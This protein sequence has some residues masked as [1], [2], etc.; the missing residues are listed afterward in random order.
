MRTNSF[1]GLCDACS[2]HVAAGSGSLT[3]KPGR[4]RTWC[5]A[6]SPRPPARGAHDGWHRLPLASLDFETTGV[7]PHADR[8]VSYALLDEP[9][10]EITGLIDPGVP[11][12]TAASDVHG[13][14]ETMVAGAPGPAEAL[15]VVIDWVQAL[16]ERRVGLVVFNA[17]Y[18][19]TMLRAEAQRHGLA[20]PDWERLLV[21]DPYVLDW[22]IERGGLGQRRLVDVAA[23]Y[24][25]RLDGAHD[26][27]VDAR[28]AREVAVELAARHATVGTTSLE[29]LMGHQ[30]TWYADRAEDWNSYARRVGRDLDDPTGWP[31]AS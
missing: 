4:W 6:C 5:L 11:I 22:G 31:L 13:I 29:D 17:C 1:D 9:G 19:L 25:V 28:A 26:A 30:R 21:V 3:G 12:P 24:G 27:T 18:D 23:Y 14:T 7:D 8:V 2:A 20:E 16:I 10:F 15:T